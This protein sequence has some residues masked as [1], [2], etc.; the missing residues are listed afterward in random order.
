MTVDEVVNR[1]FSYLSI[2]KLSEPTGVLQSGWEVEL[3]SGMTVARS[4]LQEEAGA[5]IALGADGVPHILPWVVNENTA[6]RYVAAYALGQITGEKP[7]FPYFDDTDRSG[8]RAQAI[9]VWKRW[10]ETNKLFPGNGPSGRLY[11]NNLMQC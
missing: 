3:P 7:S 8:Q 4:T 6:L 2:G 1:V 11:D 10:Y 5:L 9:E